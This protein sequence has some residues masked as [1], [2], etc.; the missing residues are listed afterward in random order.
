MSK[1][2]SIIV[3]L[4]LVCILPSVLGL[5]D[6]LYREYEQIVDAINHPKHAMQNKLS[7]ISI[8][9]LQTKGYLPPH[10]CFQDSSCI[11]VHPIQ[12]VRFTSCVSMNYN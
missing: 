6:A 3:L 2:I 8:A 7:N 11:D 10:I 9:D 1:I 4:V 5:D 12:L